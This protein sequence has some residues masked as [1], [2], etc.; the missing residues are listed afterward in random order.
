MG[1]L[2]RVLFVILFSL[3]CVA[4][5][6]ALLKCFGIGFLFFS[7]IKLFMIGKRLHREIELE[8]LNYRFLVSHGKE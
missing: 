3:I 5:V 6:I 1:F 4:F 2:L 7:R 8:L